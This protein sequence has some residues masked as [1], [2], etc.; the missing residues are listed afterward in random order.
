VASVIIFALGA[1]WLAT[2]LHLNAAASWHLA[3]APF[4]PGEAIKVTAAASIYS[5]FERW[6]RS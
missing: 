5:T 6:R 1:G 3:I 2:L 4:L